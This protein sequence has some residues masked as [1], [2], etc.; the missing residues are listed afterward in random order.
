MSCNFFLQIVYSDLLESVSLYRHLE[1]FLR[2]QSHF[3]QAP[4]LFRIR[5][6]G[7]DNRSWN[8]GLKCIVL[9]ILNCTYLRHL[10]LSE[11]AFVLI[12]H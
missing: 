3:E 4:I 2:S 9:S 11:I 10:S 1:P 12:D 5:S 8:V 7:Y 6:E